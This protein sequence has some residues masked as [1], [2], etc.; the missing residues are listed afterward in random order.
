MIL[1]PITNSIIRFVRIE[2]SAADG[3]LFVRD[4]ISVQKVLPLIPLPRPSH[5][6]T[7]RFARIVRPAP[8]VV[9]FGVFKGRR[10]CGA[11]GFGAFR[12]TSWVVYGW[13]RLNWSLGKSRW[14]VR[15]RRTRIGREEVGFWEGVKGGTPT[16]SP[17]P[18]KASYVLQKILADLDQK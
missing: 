7:M 2:H 6:R 13:P 16:P 18:P 4:Q 17:L 3:I 15:T 11:A 14:K 8:V 5:W 12:C 10:F 9:F 1:C